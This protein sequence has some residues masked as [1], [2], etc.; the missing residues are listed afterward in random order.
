MKLDELFWD[1]NIND[2]KKGYTYEDE[3]QTYRCLL[4][5]EKYEQGVIYPNK[6]RL[7]EAKKAIEIHISE[8]HSSVF[9]TLLNMDKKYTGLTDHQTELLKM[10]Y[11][12]LSDKQ[13]V[14]KT[15]AGSTS[16][17]RNQR[18]SFREKQKQ[19]KVFLAIM[20]LLEENRTVRKTEDGE[21]LI[22]I[23]GGA[24]MID[25][26][27]AITEDEKNSVLKTYFDK[28]NGLRLK[29]FPAKE[30]KKIIVLQEIVS[31]FDKTRRYTES[32]INEIIGSIY[33]DFA[34]IRR[35]LIEY[36]FMDRTQNCSEYWVK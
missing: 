3:N 26:R 22:P 2:L 24:T 14:E 20:E 33:D 12:G 9:E 5:G 10:F 1:S 11:D 16:T 32:E 4:C 34:T 28:S 30:K 29:N 36:G 25:E 31:L 27:Y 6:N 35:Y 21:K 15:S 23:H 19:A 18:F 7:L 8:E 13:I 17:I